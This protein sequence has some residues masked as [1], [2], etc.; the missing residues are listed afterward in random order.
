MC[1]KHLSTFISSFTAKPKAPGVIVGVFV[2]DGESN[3]YNHEVYEDMNPVY[4]GFILLAMCVALVSLGEMMDRHYQKNSSVVPAHT[5]GV[6]EDIGNPLEQSQDVSVTPEDD[7]KPMGKN[8]PVDPVLFVNTEN[9]PNKL[10]D[11]TSSAQQTAR[12][13]EGIATLELAEGSV[14]FKEFFTRELLIVSYLM[15]F[16]ATFPRSAKVAM[17][18]SILALQFMATSFIINLVPEWYY[19]AI[20]GIGTGF[21]LAPLLA[22][23]YY[24]PRGLSKEMVTTKRVVGMLVTLIIFFVAGGW[25]FYHTG[26]FSESEMNEWMIAY[27]VS[28]GFE[29][30]AGDVIRTLIKYAIFKQ[31]SADGKLGKF[32]RES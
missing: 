20:A 2:D 12:K 25:T 10:R 17:L 9:A 14:G 22:F 29:L 13:G 6:S 8:S 4:V 32:V 1:S 24:L 28:A 27:A 23:I 3:D 5:P 31:T 15:H 26:Q 18:F 16:R 7:V 21:I 19:A 11:L 30:I